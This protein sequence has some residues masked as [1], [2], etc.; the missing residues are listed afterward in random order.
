VTVAVIGAGLAG[1]AAA[2]P[3]VDAGVEVIVLEA[4]DG[5]GGHASSRV[6]DGFVFDEG[7][8][9]LFTK[10]DEV[11]RSLIGTN[12]SGAQTFEARV[13]NYF[14]GR[15]I[16]HPVQTNLHAVTPDLASSCVEDFL[17]APTSEGAADYADWCYAGLGRGISETFT[18]PYTRKYWTVEARDLTTD[19][20]GERVFRP[21]RDEVIRGAAGPWHDES[22]H[23]ITHFRYPREGGYQSFV[24]NLVD[25]VSLRLGDPV[26]HVDYRVQEIQ[27]QSGSRV[28]YDALISTMPLPQ[29]LARTA[30]VPRL[31]LKAGRQLRCTSVALVD[32]AL[33]R[34]PAVDAHWFY[35]YDEDLLI[36]RCSLP[37]LLSPKNVPEGC[38]AIQAEGYFAPW[39][40][41][42]VSADELA[43]R[44]TS[45]LVTI[46]MCEDSDILWAETRLIEYANVVFDHARA[47]SVA[48]VR[49][50]LEKE[51]GIT[52]A[53][54]YGLWEYLWKDGAVRSG[55]EGGRLGTRRNQRTG[56]RR[57][58][59]R[60]ARRGADC[61]MVA[62]VT[63][64]G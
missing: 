64:C 38:G 27:L 48:T 3:L 54:R 15:W 2:Q 55:W 59:G 35:V 26:D 51:A 53:G 40:P 9:V 34:P 18:F 60:R 39:R 43:G 21:T 42:P 17:H 33:R 24:R 50:W 22:H 47:E 14:R 29:L 23:Y 44:V 16:P 11:L 41:L 45:E 5:W 19:W 7:P 37:H 46:C 49:S 61:P 36:S 10:D 31:V 13:S 52:L 57:M 12:S 8:H 30:D 1:L 63:C 28:R 4:R 32:V 6:R 62:V 20:V 58:N 56:D 25:G